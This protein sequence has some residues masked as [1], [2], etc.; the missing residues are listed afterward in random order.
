MRDFPSV[1][2]ESQREEKPLHNSRAG[3]LFRELHK[4]AFIILFKQMSIY[5]KSD[6]SYFSLKI[7]FFHCSFAHLCYSFGGQRSNQWRVTWRTLTDTRYTEY[8]NVGVGA[9]FWEKGVTGRLNFDWWVR[10][11][12]VVEKE[13]IFLKFL[14]LAFV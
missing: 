4:V 13:K 5:W 6:I 10:K 1:D 3:W 11:S 12:F 2:W 7:F 14:H 8:G 9:E